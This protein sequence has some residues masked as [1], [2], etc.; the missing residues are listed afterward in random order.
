MSDAC[1]GVS[2][3][4]RLFLFYINSSAQ[5]T[6]ADSRYCNCICDRL[7]SPSQRLAV[8]HAKRLRRPNCS[9]FALIAYMLSSACACCFICL[10]FRSNESTLNTSINRRRASSTMWL[11]FSAVTRTFSKFSNV[12]TNYI[13]KLYIDHIAYLYVFM[14]SVFISN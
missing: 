11:L 7:P 5:R 2:P 9:Y 10:T 4:V 1:N 3:Y 8:E 14:S 6:N 13:F 12:C